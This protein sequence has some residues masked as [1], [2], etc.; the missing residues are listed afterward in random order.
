MAA[1]RIAFM[2][3]SGTGK[4]TVLRAVNAALQLPLVESGSRQ[5]T[6]EMGLASPY[7]VD[8]LGKRGEFQ[9]RL[10]G[11]KIKEE[12]SLDD[13]ISDRTVIDVLTYYAMHDAANIGEGHIR[14]A[15]V[16]FA[17]YTHC[18]I[19]PIDAYFNPGNDPQRLKGVGYHRVFEALAWSFLESARGVQVDNDLPRTRIETVKAGTPNNRAK[20][21][22][23]V[24]QESVGV[25]N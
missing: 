1:L 4:S 14:T 13:F 9:Q 5:V 17:R 3:A 25:S 6:A 2:G 11:R 16:N 10:L 21:I 12:A 20:F 15:L 8:A 23:N 7:D 19:F 24:I 18:F 22:L